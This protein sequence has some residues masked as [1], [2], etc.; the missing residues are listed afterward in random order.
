M[1][2]VKQMPLV[3]DFQDYNAFHVQNLISSI[4]IWHL[5]A[6]YLINYALL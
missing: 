3:L 1:R 4:V 6:V 5:L 2:L